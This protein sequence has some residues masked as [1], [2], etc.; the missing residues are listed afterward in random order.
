MS[1]DFALSHNLLVSLVD[2][3]HA[4]QT[5]R[6]RSDGRVAWLTIAKGSQQKWVLRNHGDSAA[7]V[8]VLRHNRILV[9]TR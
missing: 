8:S 7:F 1:G 2:H 6:W 3:Q 9:T 4:M 5:I